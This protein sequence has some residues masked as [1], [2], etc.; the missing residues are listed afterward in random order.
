MEMCSCYGNSEVIIF[1]CLRT[2][3]HYFWD[4]HKVLKPCIFISSPYSVNMLNLLSV[5]YTHLH[6]HG[7]R[8]FEAVALNALP[9]P[10]DSPSSLNTNPFTPI[11]FN[12]IQFVHSA[13]E[14]PNRGQT[15]AGFN[16]RN[17][18]RNLLKCFSITFPESRFWT[19]FQNYAYLP[20]SGDS[21]L[22]FT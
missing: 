9:D 16:F 13:A 22:A 14:R 10:L 1:Y 3:I 12:S 18:R 5:P 2:S 4:V 8:A 11:V 17:E 7:D 21:L 6:T 15:A 19:I 20:P